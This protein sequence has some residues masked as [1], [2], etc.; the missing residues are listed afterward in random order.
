MQVQAF[1]KEIVQRVIDVQRVIQVE[2][3]EE[4]ALALFAVLGRITGYRKTD[5]V[6]QVVTSKLW[7]EIMKATG[8]HWSDERVTKYSQYLSSMTMSDDE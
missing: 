6:R 5:S 2:L 4:E 8:V 1:D 3:T 7:R